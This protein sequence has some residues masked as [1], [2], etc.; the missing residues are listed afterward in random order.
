MCRCYGPPMP[1]TIECRRCGA[2]FEAD[3]CGSCGQR[4]TQPLFFGRLW[5]ESVAKLLEFD[6]RYPRTLVGM[7]LRPGYVIG[8]YIAG[9]RDSWMNPAKFVF[10]NASIYLLVLTIVVP[11]EKLVLGVM[12]EASR[13]VTLFAFGLIIYIAY[14][15]MLV[16]A[17]VARWLFRSTF[18]SVA[19][20]YVCMLYTYGAGILINAGLQVVFL[21]Q[22]TTRVF[23]LLFISYVF[24]RLTD[25]PLW[26]SLPKAVIVYLVY[27][28][29]ALSMVRG[30]VELYLRYGAV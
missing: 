17:V 16:A 8:E 24:V 7:V 23:M 4:R 21:E 14:V 12:P 28:V 29:T 18:R 25:E 15:Y 10:I 19:E 30:L 13:E 3:Y 27:T 6:L 1:D 26:K 11:P 2:R 9:N 22:N 5:Q 20:A